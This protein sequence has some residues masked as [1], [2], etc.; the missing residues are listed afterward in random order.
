MLHDHVFF[1]NVELYPVARIPSVL[2]WRVTVRT[3]SHVRPNGLTMRGELATSSDI[4][5][6][7]CVKEKAKHERKTQETVEKKN[8]TT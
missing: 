1:F 4:G 7:T 3:F 6:Y 8:E 2:G 5:R